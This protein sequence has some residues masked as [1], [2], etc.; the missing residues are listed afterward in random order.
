MANKLLSHAIRQQKTHKNVLSVSP[1]QESKAFTVNLLSQDNDGIIAPVPT[2]V[3]GVLQ[4][5]CEFSGFI[6]PPDSAFRFGRSM[7]AP[8]I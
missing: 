7:V 4:N 5:N 2:L 6:C 8:T 3:K 1:R